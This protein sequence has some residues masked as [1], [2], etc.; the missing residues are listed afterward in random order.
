MTIVIHIKDA[1]PGW[2]N[3]PQYVYC[4]RGSKWG[5]QYSH[6]KSSAAKFRVNTRD[7]AC[8]MFEKHQLPILIRWGEIRYLVNKILVCFCH[9]KR[10]HC[11]ALAAEANKLGA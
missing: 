5:N 8:D 6:L 11:D 7:E 3:N 9:P 10:C 4:G 2:K 1:P